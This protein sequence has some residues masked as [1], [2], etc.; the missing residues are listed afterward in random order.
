LI[1][2]ALGIELIPRVQ[3]VETSD[4]VSQE[5]TKTKVKTTFHGIMI[6]PNSA[7]QLLYSQAVNKTYGNNPEL[8]N[9]VIEN[10]T[11]DNKTET[12]SD[13]PD[14][15]SNKKAVCYSLNNNQDCGNHRKTY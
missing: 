7:E 10:D 9:P 2:L 15:D 3:A 11:D 4:S 8:G 1:V 5:Q 6:L 12:V 14:N 13:F